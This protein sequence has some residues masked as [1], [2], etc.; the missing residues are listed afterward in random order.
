MNRLLNFNSSYDLEVQNESIKGFLLDIN[1]LNTA[2]AICDI[3]NLNKI[4]IDVV[5]ERA[6][7]KPVYLVQGYLDDVLTAL[8]SQTT[9]YAMNTKKLFSGYKV[10]FDLSPSVINL[11][12]EDI[13]RI[14]LRAEGSSFT[15]LNAGT[16][17]IS[18][19]TIPAMPQETF[20]PQVKIK[21]IGNGEQYIDFQLGDDIAKI[22][23]A[24]DFTANYDASTK[25]K[26]KIGRA[27]V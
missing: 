25:A 2:G 15:D 22:T 4:S 14:K 7:Q 1:A 5:L 6:G 13:L 18:F 20:L 8:Y 23:F 17:N 9:R 10:N 24:I 12:G 11:R 21:N 27:H 16:S 3:A 19:E 26:P